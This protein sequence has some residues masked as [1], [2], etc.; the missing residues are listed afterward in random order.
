M[1]AKIGYT[2]IRTK[3]HFIAHAVLQSP[4]LHSLLPALP[5]SPSRVASLLTCPLYPPGALKAKSNTPPSPRRRCRHAEAIPALL[6]AGP[7][8]I[9]SHNPCAFLPG[10]TRVSLFG[11]VFCMCISRNKSTIHIQCTRFLASTD[12]IVSACKCAGAYIGLCQL[13]R[14]CLGRIVHKAKVW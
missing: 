8:C 2:L 1:Y 9:P 12:I 3:T 13:Q 10:T 4:A 7:V 6:C 5:S 11:T 14:S